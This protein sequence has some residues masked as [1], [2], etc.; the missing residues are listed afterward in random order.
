MKWIYC[1]VFL[2]VTPAYAGEILI[3]SAFEDIEEATNK[4]SIHSLVLF[5]V[6]GTLIVPNDAILKP[7]GKNL[8]KQLITGHVNRDLFRE[9][10]LKAPHSLVDSR[11]NALVQ[12]LQAKKIPV[13]AFTA[14][15]AKI[16]D[17]EQP[18]DWRVNE[19]YRFGFDFQSTFPNS[20]VLDFPKNSDLNS[21]P[22]F[23]SGVLFSSFH[24]KGEVLLMFLELI[25]LNPDKVIFIDDEFEH[26]RSVMTSLEKYGITCQGIHFTAVEQVPCSIDIEQARFQINYFIEHD[27][28][29]NDNEVK[30]LFNKVSQAV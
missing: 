5:D 2:F 25:K 19:L 4:L 12:K 8:F 6:D 22:M 17:T 21:F 16:N 1:F 30:E 18:G 27:L 9:I 10:R 14:A 26:V 7:K 13:L 11:L 29:L 3:T 28:W 23:K 24:P 20:V 15:P